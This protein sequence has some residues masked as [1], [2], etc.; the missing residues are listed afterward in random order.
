M[1]CF[2]Y[3][4]SKHCPLMGSLG[5]H[6]GHVFLEGLFSILAEELSRAFTCEVRRQSSG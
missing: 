2:A 3:F 4:K 5:T 1:G 6:S